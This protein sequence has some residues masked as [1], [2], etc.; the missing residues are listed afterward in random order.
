[1]NLRHAAALA[2]V[3]WYLLIPPHQDD[4]ASAPFSTWTGYSQ[5]YKSQKECKIALLQFRQ[6]IREPGAEESLRRGD[7]VSHQDLEDF[8]HAV[9]K[10]ARCIA[11]DN[12]RLK[13]K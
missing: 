10:Q 11:T 1:M 2:L 8:Q 3:G 4:G 9:D 7:G 12:P 13:E 5:T 6:M